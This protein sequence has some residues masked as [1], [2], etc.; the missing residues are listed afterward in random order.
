MNIFNACKVNNYDE[1]NYLIKTTKNLKINKIISN[2]VCLLQLACTNNNFKIVKLLIEAGADVNRLNKN[3]WSVLMYA[4]MYSDYNI[5]E[6]LCIL[7]ANK[8]NKSKDN[9][10]VFD[11]AIIRNNGSSISSIDHGGNYG[12]SIDHNKMIYNLIFEENNTIDTPILYKLPTLIPAHIKSYKCSICL[13]NSNTALLT[14]SNE[15]CSI[16]FNQTGKLNRFDCGHLVCCLIC[17]G[18]TETN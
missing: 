13:Q 4:V 11:L 18:K 15:E 9:L 17:L 5:V 1:L 12:S 7:G 14:Y 2:D 16:C 10:T 3:K 6:L 8:I